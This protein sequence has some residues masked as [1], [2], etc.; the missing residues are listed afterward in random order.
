MIGKIII[1]KSFRGCLMYCLHDKQGQAPVVKD[2]A[3]VLLYNKCYGSN[4]ELIQQFHEV[5]LLNEKVAKP[6]LHIT[7]S[8]A[9][10]EQLGRDKLVEL[11]EGCAKEFGFENNQ[12]VVIAHRDTGHQHLHI[13]ANRIGFDSRTVSDSNSYQKMAAFCRKMELKYNLQQV[14]SP[15]R[16]LSKDQRQ[17]PRLDKRKERLKENIQQCLSTS[18]SF[19]QFEERMKARGYQLLKGRGIAFS[20]EK[21]MKVKGSEVGYSLHRIERVLEQNQIKQEQN[22]MVQASAPGNERIGGDPLQKSK[23]QQLQKH[24]ECREEKPENCLGNAVNLLLTPE[25]ERSVINPQW[26]KKK[27]KKQSHRPHP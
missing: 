7:L 22:K 26:L 14:L 15:R 16:Y 6:V 11:V 24:E 5:R 25:K 4:K 20:D 9:P 17:L 19:N 2:R 12:Y 21:A 10:G 3:E 1:G 23:E 8:L 27:R 13:A 18:C